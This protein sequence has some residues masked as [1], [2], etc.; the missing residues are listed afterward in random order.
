MNTTPDSI[1]PHEATVIPESV[2]KAA[3]ALGRRGRGIP[4]S[5]TL[6]Y[7]K[8]LAD[9]MREGQKKRWEG[10]VKKAKIAKQEPVV[11]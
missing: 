6:E 8:L 2:S 7:R 1:I 4:K 3:A 11:A 10:H 5:Y 9:R